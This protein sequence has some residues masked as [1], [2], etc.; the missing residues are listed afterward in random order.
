MKT[1][2]KWTGEAVKKMHLYNIK[3]EEVALKIG[4]SR[5][6]VCKTLSGTYS[7]ENDRKEILQAIDNI[8]CEKAKQSN[9]TR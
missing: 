9:E 3:R 5:E 4:K 7:F 6:V 2:P 1:P 8:V